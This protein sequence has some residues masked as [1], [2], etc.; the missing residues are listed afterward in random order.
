M[1]PLQGFL[2]A[3][4]SFCHQQVAPSV[5]YNLLKISYGYKGIAPLELEFRIR[6]EILQSFH[7]FGAITLELI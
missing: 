1:S 2:S 4:D 7:S 6:F 3:P 5:L